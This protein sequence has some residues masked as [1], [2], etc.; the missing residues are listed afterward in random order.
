M[1]N[2][3]YRWERFSGRYFPEGS[4]GAGLGWFLQGVD[5]YHFCTEKH[6]GTRNIYTDIVHC[7]LGQCWMRATN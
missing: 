6:P 3:Y 4:F 7:T 5:E 1:L 2:Y